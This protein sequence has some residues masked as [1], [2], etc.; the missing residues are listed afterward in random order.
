MYKRI[1]L[2][3]VS[4]KWEKHIQF[5]GSTCAVKLSNLQFFFNVL[6]SK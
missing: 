4:V 2:L 3:T 1:L 6:N 5:Y